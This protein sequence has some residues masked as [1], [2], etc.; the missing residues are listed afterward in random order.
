[1]FEAIKQHPFVF[2]W[3][4]FVN[5][6]ICLTILTVSNIKDKTKIDFPDLY[7]FFKDFPKNNDIAE[8]I[9]RNIQ[10]AFVFTCPVIHIFVGFYFLFC[11]N[12]IRNGAYE[13][14]IKGLK[15]KRTKIC[16]ELGMSV[17]EEN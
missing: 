6:N 14:T 7:K 13:K 15:E 1:M 17:P 2:I 8:V 3:V 12:D 11:W 10:L 16:K 4:I 9:V 5:L